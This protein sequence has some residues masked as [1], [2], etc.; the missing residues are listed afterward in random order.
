MPQSTET[1][2]TSPAALVAWHQIVRTRDLRRLDALLHDDVTFHSPVV[3]TPQR[4]KSL[5]TLYLSGAMQ[6][7]N[8]DSFH[9]QRELIGR[10]DAVLEFSTEVDGIV[11]NGVDLIRWDDDDRI[12]DFKVMVR[13]LKA[14]NLLHRKMAE[15]LERLGAGKAA[16]GG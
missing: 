2:D 7:L 9:Y 11:I 10:R 1:S 13:P 16:S 8:N 4:G 15:M 12:V 5:T 14:I 3:H 6:V